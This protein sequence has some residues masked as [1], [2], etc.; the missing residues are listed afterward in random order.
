[1]K[2]KLILSTLL[3]FIF[4]LLSSQVPQ[5]FNYQ[6]IARDGSG[7]PIVGATIKVELSLLTDTLGFRAGTG[8]TYLWE[9]EH[10]GVVTNAFGLFTI[11]LGDP[12]ATR[13]QGVASFSVI[14][15]NKPTIYIGTKIANP[16]TYKVLGGAKL[17]S[18]PYALVSGNLSGPVKKL[19]LTSL[20]TSPDSAIFEVKNNTGQTVFAVY[21]EGV[22]VYVDNGI[23]KGVKGGF[24]IGGF[25]TDKA[26]SQNLFSVTPDSIRMYINNLPAGKGTKGGFAIGGF[27]GTKGSDKK[28]LS[29]YGANTIDTISNA[30]QILWYPNKEAFMAGRITI[31]HP[32]SVG[33]NSFSTGYKNMAIGDYSHALGYQAI[34][35]GSY[36]TAIGRSAVSGQNSFALGNFSTALGNDSYAIG[37]ASQ[38]SGS[39]SVALGVGSVSSGTASLSLG[40]QSVAT[41]PYAVAI[42]FQSKA[43]QSTAHAF[44]LKA[45]ASGIGSLAL[46]MYS[47]AQANYSTSLG[48]HSVASNTYS[49][50]IGYYALASGL[51]SYAIG[52]QAESAGENSF[53]IG[54]YGLNDNGTPNTNRATWTPG[55]YSLAFGMGAQATQLGAMA[56]GVN[57]TASG[58]RSVSIG[59]GTVAGADFSTAMGYR[60]I[61]NGFKSIAIGGQYNMTFYK[62]VWLY[63]TTEQKWTFVR[64]AVPIDKQNL[65]EGDYSIAI[66][67][68]NLARNGGL[69]LGTNNDAKAF[70]SVSIGHSNVA[71]SSFSFAAGFANSSSGL[72]AFAMGENLIASSANSFVIGAFN[73]PLG[74]SNEWIPSEPLFVVGN[75]NPVTRSNAFMILKDGNIVLSP[76]IT[77]GPGGAQLYYDPVDGLLKKVV[78]SARYKSEISTLSDVSWL[79]DLRPVSF[80]YK[81][82]LNRSIQYGLVAEDVE[83]T[84]PN[85][86][87]YQDGMPEGVN[88]HGLFAPIIKAMQDQEIR[89]DN[90]TYQ[91]NKLIR[92]ND[93]LKLRLDKLESLVS[94]V[95]SVMR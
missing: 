75:G 18:V 4:C 39:T 17:W 13:I 54:S 50:A 51:D 29:L 35:R 86:V 15:W 9:E 92:E 32:D 16:T 41:S 26:A 21:N 55:Y 23:A 78:S 30:S 34:A 53:A 94:S 71:D 7:N 61:A 11:V 70:G 57:S 62:L 22:R 46:G 83:K 88:Y 42:G 59:F 25:G 44:G 27:G 56:L 6:A 38:A 3:S 95:L 81:N 65:S 52:S 40:F 73:L 79:Y 14:D 24:A 89:I 72:K 31:V 69:A 37:S 5:G 90:L 74:T 33:R 91:N 76:N 64:E 68:G 48:Y 19:A 47:L 85:L 82:D 1:M 36:S 43:L 77:T 80:I 20:N 2:T 67:N 12:S 66:G 87:F 49:M 84:R 93:E 10:T 8:G 63:N 58:P 28:Y 60:S 45:E